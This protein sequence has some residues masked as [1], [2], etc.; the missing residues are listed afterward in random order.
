MNGRRKVGSVAIFAYKFV[1]CSGNEV[2]N[3][4]GGGTGKGPKVGQ[5]LICLRPLSLHNEIDLRLI[6]EHSK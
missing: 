5:R 3:Y 2:R 4:I 1:N 6:V